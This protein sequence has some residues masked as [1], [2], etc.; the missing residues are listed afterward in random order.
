MYIS[1]E[2]R[3]SSNGILLNYKKEQSTD[4]GT[5][6]MKPENNWKR[7]DT[8]GHSMIPYNYMKYPK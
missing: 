5:T 7:P 4:N 2:E 6:W 3:T 8:K 1:A